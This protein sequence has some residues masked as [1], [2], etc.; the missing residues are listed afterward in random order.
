MEHNERNITNELNKEIAFFD[1]V[2]RAPVASQF[3]EVLNKE[4]LIF[5]AKLHKIFEFRR[6]DLLHRRIE[7]EQRIAQ[8]KNDFRSR[9]FEMVFGILFNF[10]SV[11]GEMPTF[12][13]STE[14]I[15]RDPNWKLLP[16]TNPVGDHRVS[17]D[18]EC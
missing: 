5:V 16:V 10:L 4:A 17:L 9:V 18:I 3:A 8:G 11:P 7:R 14:H 6:Q 2:V 12:L 15:R 13:D 1:V